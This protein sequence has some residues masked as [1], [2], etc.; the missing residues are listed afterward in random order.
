[1]PAAAPPPLGL[2]PSLAMVARRQSEALAVCLEHGHL[3]GLP[4]L[5]AGLGALLARTRRELL[6]LA[7]D[8]EQ[9]DALPPGW[10]GWSAADWEAYVEE[11]EP[12]PLAL[13]PARE[14]R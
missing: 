4:E 10:R 6:L 8:D 3:E 7:L 1:M 12:E 2:H 9:D 14:G 13:A 5:V 11:E